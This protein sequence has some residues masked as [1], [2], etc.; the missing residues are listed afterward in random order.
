MINQLYNLISEQ[1]RKE[2]EKNLMVILIKRK[3]RISKFFS[4]FPNVEWD[5]IDEYV[6][7]MPKNWDE[8]KDII[9]TMGV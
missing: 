7:I 9:E 6:K 1:E 8:H 5:I 2:K 4:N 3:D